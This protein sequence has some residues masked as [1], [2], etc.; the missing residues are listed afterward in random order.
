M[1]FLLLMALN[2]NDTTFFDA[3]LLLLM[4]A[5]DTLQLTCKTPLVLFSFT[6]L[7]FSAYCVEFRLA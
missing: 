2:L 6:D 5:Q 4:H 7:L 3:G 1:F